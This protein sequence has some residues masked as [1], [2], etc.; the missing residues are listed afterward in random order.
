MK[1]TYHALPRNSIRKASRRS[2]IAFSDW[3][4]AARDP[5][6]YVDTVEDFFDWHG[7][8]QDLLEDRLHHFPDERAKYIQM[9]MVDAI[10]AIQFILSTNVDRSSCPSKVLPVALYP[11]AYGR[12]ARM[13]MLFLNLATKLSSASSGAFSTESTGTPSPQ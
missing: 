4:R 11:G 1:R 12:I 9:E 13:Q 8:L 7:S 6:E 10:T 5:D 3:A 2:K